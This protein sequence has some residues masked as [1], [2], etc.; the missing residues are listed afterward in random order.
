MVR[1]AATLRA[2]RWRRSP[3]GPAIWVGIGSMERRCGRRALPTPNGCP[4]PPISSRSAASASAPATWSGI[5]PGADSARLGPGAGDATLTAEPDALASIGLALSRLERTSA[6]GLGHPPAAIGYGLE[7]HGNAWIDAAGRADA[8]FHETESEPAGAVAG[9]VSDATRD[10]IGARGGA[11]NRHLACYR[12]RRR[13]T[14]HGWNLTG[15]RGWRE[16][17]EHGARNLSSARRR[18]EPASSP[19]APGGRILIHL[20]RASNG[21]QRAPAPPP[22]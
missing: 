20:S 13:G 8:L 5:L 4:E 16:A 10:L 2:C 19:A 9:S 18:R 6:A 12:R 3:V 1:L 21:R 11:R 17:P 14:R 15:T 7:R 22:P